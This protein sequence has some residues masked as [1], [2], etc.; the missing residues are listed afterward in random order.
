[1]LALF[2]L[3]VPF[4][5]SSTRTRLVTSIQRLPKPQSAFITCQPGPGRTEFWLCAEVDAEKMRAAA[6][7]QERRCILR[8]F[9]GF[10]F[11]YGSRG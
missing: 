2:T 6:M 5:E 8:F 11:P 9:I 3:T 1:M 7:N 10:S 4:P